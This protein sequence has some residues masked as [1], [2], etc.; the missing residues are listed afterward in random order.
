MALTSDSGSRAPAP[1]AP[2]AQVDGLSLR[3]KPGR[4]VL[5]GTA[6]T[7]ALCDELRA[8]LRDRGL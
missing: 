6:V 5:E 1:A 8:W 7:E 2:P 4:I 3:A